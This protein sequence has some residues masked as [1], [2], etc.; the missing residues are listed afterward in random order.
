MRIFDVLRGYQGLRMAFV[1]FL[2]AR[3]K[4]SQGSDLGRDGPEKKPASEEDGR[5]VKGFPTYVK[6]VSWNL[7]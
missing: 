2:R 7:F 1:D 5:F 6:K 4:P 3:Q